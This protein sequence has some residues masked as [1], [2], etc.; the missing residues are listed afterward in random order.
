MTPEEAMVEQL[1]DSAEAVDTPEESIVEETDESEESLDSLSEE[2][3]EGQEPAE[4]PQEKGSRSTSE[5][6]WIKQRVNKAV[7]RAVAETEARMQAKFDEQMAPIRDKMLTDE[8]RE[9]VRQGEFKSMERAKEYL[10]LKQGLPVTANQTG[11]EGSGPERNEKGQFAQRTDPA[12]AARVDMLRH[13]ADRIKAAGG[14]DVIA[15]FQ[16]NE[17]IKRKVISGELDFYDVAE[18]MKQPQRRK[19]PAPVRSPNGASGQ[20][21]PNA[22]DS[23]SDEQFARME[24]RIKEGARYSL[25]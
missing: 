17:E 20:S 21:N 2:S 19:P 18:Q 12:V 14:P 11:A 4:E 15:E 1:D 16:G 3:D 24:K 6:G 23:M 8:A 25:K 7:Q 9:L 13:Q 22:I 5:P 10:Q